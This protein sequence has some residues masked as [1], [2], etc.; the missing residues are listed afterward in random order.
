MSYNIRYGFK[1][2]S[3]KPDADMGLDTQEEPPE[4]SAMVK[5][6][7]AASAHD[8]IRDFAHG[9]ATPVGNMSG[10]QISGGQK[11]RVAIARA[12]VDRPACLLCDEATAALDSRSE[13]AV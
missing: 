1:Q 11:Q 9:Y 6:A 12:L 4:N 7:Q 8:F 10:S 5:A 2:D 3:L 13:K